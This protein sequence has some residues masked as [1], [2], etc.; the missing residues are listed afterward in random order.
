MDDKYLC[1]YFVTK[2]LPEKEPNLIQE[3]KE[4][5]AKQLPSYLVPQ[6]FMRLD[7]FPVTPNGKLDMNRLPV[8]NMQVGHH[9][10]AAESDG[11]KVLAEIWAGILNRSI[12][13]LS[14][15]SSFFEMGGHSLKAAIMAS[16]IH[17]RLNIK[18]PM[19]EIFNRPTIRE[20]AKYMKEVESEAYEPIPRVPEQVFYDLSSAQRKLYF[21]QQM[22]PNDTSYN[23]PMFWEMTGSFNRRQFEEAFQHLLMRHE[24][25]RTYF[26][27][28]NGEPYQKLQHSAVLEIEYHDVSSERNPQ[29]AA[30]R[31]INE[32]VRPFDLTEVPLR[33]G[34]VELNTNSRILMVDIHHIITDGVSMG[35][36]AQ[37]FMALFAGKSLPEIKVRYRDYA[38]W[39]KQLCAPDK[40]KKQEMYWQGIF[41]GEL[42]VLNLPT[43]FQRPAVRSFE[44]DQIGFSIPEDITQKL[45]KLALE[46]DATLFIVLLAV[47]YILLSKLSGQDDIIVGTDT[48]GREHVDLHDVIG[49]F[50]NTLALRNFPQEMLSFNEFLAEVRKRLLEAYENQDFQFEDLVDKVVVQRDLSRHPLFDV[51]FGF[52][53]SDME[54]LS[55]S[56]LTMRAYPYDKKTSIFD[57]VLQGYESNQDIVFQMEYSSTLFARN[58]VE[59]FIRCFNEIIEQIIDNR[60]LKISDIRVTHRLR[61][62]NADKFN[63]LEGEFSF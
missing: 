10:T 49:N 32:F 29:V 7:E 28:L 14:I 37:D 15:D 56:G 52:L 19:I 18:V 13:T 62:A 20:L 17:K 41:D 44:G 48:A 53:I 58:T 39:Y 35:I 6:Y 50:A 24:S 22:N 12:E 47:Y 25:L 61:S 59:T 2:Q 57:L 45:K 36:L 43:D 16:R 21:L 42:P 26:V 55:M 34:L 63:L 51:M 3:I 8:P 1:A 30:E 33:V 46:E 9:F 40:M 4:H 54:D 23:L 27:L 11:E 60:H 38:A 5:L 31:I